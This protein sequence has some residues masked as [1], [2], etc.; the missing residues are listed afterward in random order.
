MGSEAEKLQESPFATMACRKNVYGEAMVVWA[1]LWIL[2]RQHGLV[3]PHSFS[4]GLATQTADHQCDTALFAGSASLDSCRR[5]P[6]E[7]PVP[8]FKEISSGVLLQD[9]SQ[10]RKK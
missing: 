1:Q 10:P 3:R 4:P 2:A 5:L 8:R 9:L 7:Y 6:Y